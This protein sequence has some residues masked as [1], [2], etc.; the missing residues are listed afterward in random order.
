V[1]GK[2]MPVNDDQLISQEVLQAELQYL[3]DDNGLYL[4]C[5]NGKPLKDRTTTQERHDGLIL[6]H[7]VYLTIRNG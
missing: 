4:E 1:E 5:L 3:Q 2:T 7:H 6:F